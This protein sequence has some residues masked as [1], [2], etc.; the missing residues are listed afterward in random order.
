MLKG[1]PNIRFNETVMTEIKMT[2][3]KSAKQLNRAVGVWISIPANFQ[4]K[5]Y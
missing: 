4:L 5:G 1:I 3:F 2:K